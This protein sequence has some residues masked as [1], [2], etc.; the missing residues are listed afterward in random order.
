MQ[1]GKLEQ[2]I[3]CFRKAA[4]LSPTFKNA[5]INLK[6]AESISESIFQAV[7]GMRDALNFTMQ[8][9]D[10][11]VKVIELLEKKEKLEKTLKHF[12]KTLSLQ[13]G[14]TEFDQNNIA[15]VRKVK[16]KYEQKLDL[17]RRI[18]EVKPDSAET[19]YHIA[20]IYSR[21]GQI[22]QSISW[23]NQAIAK[24]FERWELIETDSDLDLIR[25]DDN[26]PPRV[27]G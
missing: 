22:Q 14:F 21:K 23:L 26:F 6:L 8:T 1:T 16:R 3:L 2:A 4:K 11:D 12:Q 24:G 13:P 25:D 19:N 5:L 15:I 7:S 17:F 20:C 27:A 9:K 10:L 18:S